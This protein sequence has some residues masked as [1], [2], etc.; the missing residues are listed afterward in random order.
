MYSNKDSTDNNILSLVS[1]LSSPPTS[2][3]SSSSSSSLGIVLHFVRN[4]NKNQ[5]IDAMVSAL[6]DKDSNDDNYTIQIN[7]FQVILNNAISNNGVSK[8]D[9]IAFYY[10]SGNDQT[11]SSISVLINNKY[12]DSIYHASLLRYKLLN[13]YVG[14]Q[15][16]APEAVKIIKQRYNI[17]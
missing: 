4:V 10:Y 5:V 9:E 11:S 3:T 13:L 12:I 15:S 17:N 16:I 8:D 2:L 1:S 7:Q 6:I 14:N